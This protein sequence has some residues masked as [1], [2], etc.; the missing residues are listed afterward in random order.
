LNGVPPM[1]T[2][3]SYFLTEFLMVISRAGSGAT[4]TTSSSSAA[5]ERASSSSSSPAVCSAVSSCE[6]AQ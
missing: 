4:P 6:Y 3:G 2:D 5:P 1:M